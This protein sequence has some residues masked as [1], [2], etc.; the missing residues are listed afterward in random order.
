MVNMHRI[1]LARVVDCIRDRVDPA[2]VIDETDRLDAL[3]IDSMA[4]ITVLVVLEDEFGLEVNRMLDATP[5]ETLEELVA[6][7]VRAL[8]YK[9]SHNV[10]ADAASASLADAGQP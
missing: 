5:P 7:A 1:I 2:R 6:L 4:T 3:G 10:T 8:P 9:S